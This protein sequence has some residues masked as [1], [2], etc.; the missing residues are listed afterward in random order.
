[1]RSGGDGQFHDQVVARPGQSGDRV[2]LTAR[3]PDT[4]EREHRLVSST[5]VPA[6]SPAIDFG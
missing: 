5:R 6:R 3:P 1:M 4:D 2:D